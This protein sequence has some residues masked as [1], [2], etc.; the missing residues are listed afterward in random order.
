MI[1][2]DLPSI[3]IPP[4]TGD[5]PSAR[6]WKEVDNTLS[7]YEADHYLHWDELLQKALP[8]KSITH[9]QWW[10]LLKAKRR[11]R[12]Q[13]LPLEIESTTAYFVQDDKLLKKNSKIE[14][15][16]SREFLMATP[17]VHGEFTEEAI[18]ALQLS[19]VDVDTQ[20]A[21]QVLSTGEGSADPAI[22]LAT[23]IETLAL[24]FTPQMPITTATLQQWAAALGTSL[25]KNVMLDKLLT[26]FNEAEDSYAGFLPPLVKAAILHTAVMLT[27]PFEAYNPV[28][29]SLLCHAFLIKESYPLFSYLGLSQYLSKDKA[30]YFKILAYSQS[31][32]QDLTY[33][34]NYLLDIWFNALIALKDKVGIQLQEEGMISA[35]ILRELNFRQLAF[36]TEA[37]KHPDWVYRIAAYKKRFGI[38]YETARTDLMKLRRWDL[39]QEYKIGKAFCYTLKTNMIGTGD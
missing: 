18:Y 36:L 34:I 24:S 10:Q 38:T 11:A 31:D 25:Q 28:F 22:M 5:D 6:F 20:A 4:K 8:L 29:A 37:G 13:S 7:P 19:G 27:E 14:R 12:V 21:R 35:Q 3:E 17:F 9:K 15:G 32:E 26:F 23:Q 1:K 16:L 39:M 30:Q 33:A 2:S